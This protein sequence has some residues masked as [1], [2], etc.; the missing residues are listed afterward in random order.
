[1]MKKYVGLIV[2]T[3]FLFSGT[4]QAQEIAFKGFR[5]Q[6]ISSLYMN[7]GNE[8]HV[9]A[10]DLGDSFQPEFAVKGATI[11]KSA[12]KNSV[13]I[14]PNESKVEL[15]VSNNGKALATK[16][17]DVQPVP[18]PSVDLYLNGTRMD[19]KKGITTS[20]FDKSISVKVIPDE[21][22]ANQV[23]KDAR[24]RLSDWEITLAKGKRAVQIEEGDKQTEF[25][26]T[27]FKDAVK[28][29]D[30]IVLELKQIQRMNFK[31]D[32][33]DVFGEDESVVFV[34]PIK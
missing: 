12:S 33:E 16:T 1:M 23:P 4:L 9:N 21:N 2:M 28:Q 26:L 34:I 29:D 24:F 14:I 11:I 31:N 19:L 18:K 5:N 22:F 25:P 6:E 20:D 8:I 3:G 10:P 27:R 30:R 15:T 13:L 7:C 32:V 17:F